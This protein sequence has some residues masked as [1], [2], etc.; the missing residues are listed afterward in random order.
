LFLAVPLIAKYQDIRIAGIAASR[1]AA[2]ECGIRPGACEDASARAAITE[3][4]RRRHFSRHDHDVLTEDVL[5]VEGSQDQRNRFWVDRRGVS[6]LAKPADVEVDVTVG[7][8]D[9]AAGAW[10]RAGA[11]GDAGAAGAV[12][13]AAALAVSASVGPHAF[14]LDVGHGMVTARVRAAV[15]L[16]RTLAQWLER[17]DGMQ[18]A[19]GG[20]TALLVDAWNASSASDGEPRSF[21]ARVDGGRRLPGPAGRASEEAI[22][23][24][25]APVRELITGPLLAPIEPRGRLFRYHEIDVDRV[26]ADR[27]ATP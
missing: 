14:G 1:T 17:P 11:D 27:I 19:L 12:A 22:D 23:L 24:L 26:P 18:L 20:K 4:L 25:Y 7:R 9:A 10:G 3:D 5:A 16:N 15:S 21:E 13:G 8:S 2:F 6:L